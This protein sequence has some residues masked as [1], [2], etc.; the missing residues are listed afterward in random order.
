LAPIDEVNDQMTPYIGREGTVVMVLPPEWDF[1]K[2]YRV[3]F[4][5]ECEPLAFMASEL[6]PA[7]V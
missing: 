4:S 7:N 3:E 6:E 1:P 2:M 5:E